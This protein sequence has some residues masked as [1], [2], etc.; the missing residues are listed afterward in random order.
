MS[1]ILVSQLYWVIWLSFAYYGHSV[2]GIIAGSL[3]VI[4][5][6]IVMWKIQSRSWK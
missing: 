3:F 6:W 5:C 2:A 4:V 1:F